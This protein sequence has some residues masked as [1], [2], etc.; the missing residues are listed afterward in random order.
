MIN[1]PLGEQNLR[2]PECDSSLNYVLARIT[3]TL[4]KNTIIH[5]VTAREERIIQYLDTNIDPAEMMNQ[6]CEEYDEDIEYF[7]PECDEYISSLTD[8]LTEED[9][10]LVSEG[11][12][13]LN[14]KNEITERGTETKTKN[15][16][17]TSPTEEIHKQT[18]KALKEL[19]NEEEKDE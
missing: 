10:K 4:R 1:I 5:A 2:C 8:L 9:R 16:K 14:D 7:C 19:T 11:K 3:I 15:I 18:K 12:A 17:T 13:R 6:D